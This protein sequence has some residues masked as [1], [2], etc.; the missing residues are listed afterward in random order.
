MKEDQLE[1]KDFSIYI[2][3]WDQLNWTLSKKYEIL[4]NK[5]TTMK[6]VAVQ[7]HTL[8]LDNN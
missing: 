3:V 4:V 5:S 2:R 8:L 6:D 1:M 7:I